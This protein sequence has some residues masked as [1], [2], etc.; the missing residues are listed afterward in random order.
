MCGRSRLVDLSIYRWVRRNLRDPRFDRQ[1]LLLLLIV[2]MQM[3]RMWLAELFPEALFQSEFARMG[4]KGSR[5]VCP[6]AVVVIPLKIWNAI[7][8]E[9]K[10]EEQ[11]RLLV[12]ARL[13][14]LQRQINPHFLFNTL[15]SIASLVRSRP[16]LAREMIVRLPN[17]LRMLLKDHEAYVPFREELAIH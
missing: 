13:D 7:R 1:I 17:I 4:G 2:A 14:A 16:E 15:N 3:V 5:W 10:H 6:A 9:R 8:I 11:R 12:E